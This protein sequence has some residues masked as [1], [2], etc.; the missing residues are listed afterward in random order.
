MAVPYVVEIWS[1]G[2]RTGRGMSIFAVA[3]RTGR[4]RR[5]RAGRMVDGW[6]WIGRGMWDVMKQCKSLV[7]VCA[8]I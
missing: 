1:S 7:C 3:V 4:I 6:R 5:E 8:Q 2:E